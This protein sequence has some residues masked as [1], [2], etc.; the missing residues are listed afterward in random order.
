MPDRIAAATRRAN[1]PSCPGNPCE[2]PV[3][4]ESPDGVI[5]WGKKRKTAYHAR[6]KCYTKRP[7]G[8]RPN[9]PQSAERFRSAIGKKVFS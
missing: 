4:K 6:L 9:N 3:R 2:N 1:R 7:V 8:K 5:D